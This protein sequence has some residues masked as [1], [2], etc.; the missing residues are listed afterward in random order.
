MTDQQGGGPPMYR[1]EQGRTYMVSEHGKFYWTGSSWLHESR[2]QAQPSRT[3]PVRLHPYSPVP[4]SVPAHPDDL[5]PPNF[6]TLDPRLHETI[7]E[8][9]AE[10]TALGKLQRANYAVGLLGGVLA[11]LLAWSLVWPLVA[12]TLRWLAFLMGGV[13]GIAVVRVVVAFLN[14]RAH[15]HW[16]ERGKS[17][18]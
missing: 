16:Y 12:P 7:L 17:K 13:A 14:E 4:D 11:G 15:R 6:R 10:V 18:F 9:H 2:V 1:D 8:V 5:P 3:R